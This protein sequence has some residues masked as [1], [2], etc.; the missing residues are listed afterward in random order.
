[1]S[2]IR[3]VDSSTVWTFETTRFRYTFVLLEKDPELYLQFHEYDHATLCTAR[4]IY[5]RNTEPCRSS[6]FSLYSRVRLCLFDLQLIDDHNKTREILFCIV[7]VNSFVC[8]A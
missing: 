7:L 4:R 8:L 2:Y 1:M 5:D 3:Q 6:Y